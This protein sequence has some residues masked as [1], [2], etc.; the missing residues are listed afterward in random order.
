M[1][2]KKDNRNY[3]PLN[4]FKKIIII[5]IGLAIASSLYIYSC[6]CSIQ[7]ISSLNYLKPIYIFIKSLDFIPLGLIVLSIIHPTK[8]VLR[9]QQI[10]GCILIGSVIIIALLHFVPCSVSKTQEHWLKYSLYCREYSVIT[11]LNLFWFG[12]L[13]VVNF[14]L[15]SYLKTN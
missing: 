3:E 5:L 4:G 11:W 2:I 13:G 6:T 7:D 9:Y 10:F 14:T 1:I 8:K 12:M 15:P